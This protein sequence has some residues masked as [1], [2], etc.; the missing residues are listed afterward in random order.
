MKN[1]L[2]NLFYNKKIS[3]L[4]VDGKDLTTKHDSILKEKKLNE[5]SALI[6]EIT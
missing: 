4:D 3:D 2:Q 5:Y 6:I 1:L